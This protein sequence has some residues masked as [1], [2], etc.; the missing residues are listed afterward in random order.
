[1]RRASYDTVARSPDISA[2][3][4]AAAVTPTINK[5]SASA[6]APAPKIK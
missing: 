1:M 2:P 4:M 5:P 6:S 3:Q